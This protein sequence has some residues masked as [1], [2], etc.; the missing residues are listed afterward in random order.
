MSSRLE[1][2]VFDDESRFKDAIAHCRRLEL[3]VVD[4]W[5]PYPLHGIE[6]L[7]GIRPTRLPWVTLVAAAV[8]LGLALWFQYWSSAQDWP[9]NIG[10][11]PFDSLPAFVPVAFELLILFGGLATAFA[12]FLRCGLWPGK[13]EKPVDPRVSD[14]CFALLVER[15]GSSLN[16]DEIAALW[17]EHGA[18]RA[19]SEVRAS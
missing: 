17:N 8:G 14:D 3:D 4:A 13:R 9:L 7:M 18:L 10:G 6:E 15:Q 19:W 16:D 1:Y 2:A 12:L 5:T 11:K